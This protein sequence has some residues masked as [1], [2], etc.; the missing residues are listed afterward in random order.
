[1]LLTTENLHSFEVGNPQS[2]RLE[3]TLDQA[4]N[5]G[6]YDLAGADMLSVL[7]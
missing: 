1:M 7:P 4:E 3:E 6:A 5:N 2:P